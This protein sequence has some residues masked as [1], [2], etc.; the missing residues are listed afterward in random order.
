MSEITN[1]RLYYLAAVAIVAIVLISAIAVIRPSPVVQTAPQNPSQKTIQVTGV[2]TV[3]APPDQA[4][5]VLAVQTQADS[6]TVAASD[7]AATMTKVLEGL[8]NIGI[9][10]KSIETVSYTISPVYQNN[11]DQTKPSTIIGYS[12]VNTIQVNL[13]DFSLVG[14]AIDAAVSAGANVVQGITFTFSSTT[15]ATLQRQALGQAVQSA[16]GQARAMAS[17]L[18]VTIVGPISVTPGYNFQPTYERLS[19]ASQPTTPIQ[20]G[21]LQVTATVQVTYEFE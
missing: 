15:L 2:S 18:G 16:D 10:Q 9:D 17:S 5:L 4:I 20:P 3:S 6:A 1:R 7:N 8:S 13:E 12:A 19:T 14:K 21:T 11:P